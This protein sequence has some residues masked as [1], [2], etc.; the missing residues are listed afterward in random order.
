MLTR[1]DIRTALEALGLGPGDTVL[2]HSSLSSFGEVDGGAE[3]V[4][5]AILELIGSAGT[6]VVPTFNYTPGLFDPKTT[7]SVCGAIT[8]AVRKR[9]NAL[10]SDHP[11]HSVAAI[12][13]LAEVITEGQED[14]NAFG[15]GSSLY[16][17]LQAKG[18]V[19]LLGVSHIA[20]SIIH[21]AEEMANLPYLDRSRQI[22][23]RT[24]QGKIARKWIRRPGCS[25][26][27]NVIEEPLQE[28]DAIAETF[29]GSC[30]ARLMTARSVVNAAVNMLKFDPESL[31][32]ERPDCSACAEARAMITAKE[33][34]KQD[35]EVMELAAEEDRTLRLI[36]SRFE[37]GRIDFF[38]SE[39]EDGPSLN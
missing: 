2:V 7:P 10:R 23:F 19:L 8:E 32:C 6:L 15:R 31:L 29:I 5:D 33:I 1:N 14:V 17:L 28:E 39:P 3:G 24:R 37:A 12:G 11:T 30:R 38:T 26:G 21:V 20:S 22:E 13:P 25:I 36:E 4:V 18:K 34:E 27:F 16:R 9:T 35:Q